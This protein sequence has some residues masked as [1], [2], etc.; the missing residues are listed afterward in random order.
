MKNDRETTSS[1]REKILSTAHALFYTQGIRAT[2]VDTIIAKSG[3]AKMTFYKHFPSK[4]LLINEILKRRDENWLSW[5]KE[6]VDRNAPKAADKPLAIFDALEE[7]FCESDFRGC[8][9][10]NAVVE[11]TG[12]QGEES[13]FA[14]LHKKNQLKYFEELIRGAGLKEPKKLA[15][16]ILLLVD[17]AVVKA[18]VECSPK[19]AKLAKSIASVLIE[20][21][22]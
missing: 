4:Q 17:G 5:F 14:L 6:R 11:A 20:Q 12:P 15:E 1:A 8:A 3:V 10:L 9:F 13:E 7:W 16:Q 19:S 22:Q 18:Q 2:G 21:A